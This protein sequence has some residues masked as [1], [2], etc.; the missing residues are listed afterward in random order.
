MLGL[1]VGNL[2]FV[3]CELPSAPIPWV[4]AFSFLGL[5]SLKVV[6]LAKDCHH[7][8]IRRKPILCGDVNHTRHGPRLLSRCQGRRPP[9][10]TLDRLD[11]ADLILVP[12]AEAAHR[13][14]LTID[15][16]R[17]HIRRGKLKATKGNDRRVRV[18]IDPTAKL[19]TPVARLDVHLDRHLDRHLDEPTRQ[20]PSPE[21]RIETELRNQ[22]RA[23]QAELTAERARGAA[24][25]AELRADMKAERDRHD[26]EIRRMVGQFEAERSIWTERVDSAE[27]RAEQATAALNDLVN[28]ILSVIP[29]PQ[30]AEPWWARW[31]SGSRRSDIRGS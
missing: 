26:A 5:R 22:L 21:S 7:I 19:D 12:V 20:A 30:P 9:R 28:R 10:H 13:L 11:M 2:R 23:A 17:Q 6:C 15:T 18:W 24:D 25:C 16:I 29:A 27:V 1:G 3:R 4:G 8:L 31:L 14:G